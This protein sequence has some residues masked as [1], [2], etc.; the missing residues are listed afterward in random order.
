MKTSIIKIMTV[1]FLS[2]ALASAQAQEQAPKAGEYGY[3]I[4]WGKNGERCPIDIATTTLAAKS[5]WDENVQ[6]CDFSF[7]DS[8]SFLNARSAIT[9]WIRSFWRTNGTVL[10]DCN[11]YIP[12]AG[13][14]FRFVIKTYKHLAET[15]KFNYDDMFR[16][17][18]DDPVVDPVVKPGVKLLS[19]A[20]GSNE[21]N[22]KMSELFSCVH[23]SISD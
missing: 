14:S 10:N 3:L 7:V 17:N 6:G 19:R 11:R 22:D 18:P 4:L 1:F 21:T 13:Y 2:F 20:R 5:D 9:V 23:I 15:D 12:D 16:V 8:F